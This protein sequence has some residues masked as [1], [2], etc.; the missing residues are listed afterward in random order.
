MPSRLLKPAAY[1]ALAT[2]SLASAVTRWLANR[3]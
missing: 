3:A 2:F 1:A